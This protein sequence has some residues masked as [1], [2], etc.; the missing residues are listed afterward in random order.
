MPAVAANLADV[1]SKALASDPLLSSAEFERYA[2]RGDQDATCGRLWPQVTVPGSYVIFDQDEAGSVLGQ[3]TGTTNAEISGKQG[4]IGLALNQTLFDMPTF[5]ACRRARVEVNRGNV[6]YEQALE[7]LIYRSVKAYIDVL[8]ARSRAG[9]AG[10]KY[11]LYQAQFKEATKGYDVAKTVSKLELALATERWKK[12]DADRIA[13][14]K[15]LEVAKASLAEIT[16]SAFEAG[17]LLAIREDMVIPLPDPLEPEHWISLAEKENLRL[18]ESALTVQ[19]AEY[20]MK[21]ANG[22]MFPSVDMFARHT[23]FDNDINRAGVA[24]PSDDD[25]FTTEAVGVAV[26]WPLFTGGSN[27]GAA[28]AA[29]NRFKS[30]QKKH[31]AL[32][33]GVQTE[34]KAALGVLVSSDAAIAAARSSLEAAQ[35]NLTAVEGGI[36]AKTKT[37]TDLL[38]AKSIVLEAEENVSAARYTYVLGMVEFWQSIG[39]LSAASVEEINALLIEKETDGDEASSSE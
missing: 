34:V 15:A 12:A 3:D 2:V 25:G 5:T 30:E 35:A 10:A 31:E 37:A 9:T 13:A 1:F 11:E 17:N 14:E 32:V 19:I 38:D 8:A 16:G 22:E 6:V 21:S 33:R 7:S 28:N 26:S 23:R 24:L 4:R 27:K 20:G 29:K 18:L 39:A 36:R